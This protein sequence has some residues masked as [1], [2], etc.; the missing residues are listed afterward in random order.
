MSE[1]RRE[2][3]ESRLGVALA[4]TVAILAVELA[5]GLLSHSLALLSD[6]GHVLT[7]VFALGL[8]WFAVVQ[9]RRPP[10]ARRTYGYHRVGILAALVNAT[11]LVVIVVAIVYEA[12]RRLVHPEPVQGGVVV[13]SA[14]FAIAINGF[15]GLRLRGHATNL[16]VRAALL[17]VTGDLVASVGVVVAGLV[18][19]LTGWLYID[20][21]LSIAISALIAWGALRILLE[22]INVLLEGTPKGIDLDAV[23]AEISSVPG[24]KLHDLHIWSVAPEQMALSC[25][26]VVE[27]ASLAEAEHLVRGLEQRVCDRFGIGHTTIQ[28]ESCHPCVD[29]GHGA[30]QH[31][32]PHPAQL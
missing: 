26:V 16:N 18:I 7:D 30:G 17:H 4:L 19:L 6:A 14:L 15:I 27:A 28:V 13:A 1:T 20:P 11:T 5:G 12:A 29:V 10:D 2:G 31:N 21:L 9:S 8:A 25:H 3:S 22:S 23:A 32:H 24:V